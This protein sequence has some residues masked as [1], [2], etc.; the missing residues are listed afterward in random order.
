M[1]SLMFAFGVLV[2]ACGG[3]GS[4][5]I[6]SCQIT[7]HACHEVRGEGT[8]MDLARKSCAALEKTLAETP[9][10][11]EGRVASCDALGGTD[12]FYQ[13]PTT[14]YEKLC[15]AEQGTFKTY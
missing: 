9:C 15:A 5:K 1:K 14:T 12:Y 11:T 10:A 2:A 6:V 7:A 13:G 3:G 4:D 8:P